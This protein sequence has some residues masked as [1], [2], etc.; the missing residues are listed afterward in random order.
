MSCCRAE[1]VRF[2]VEGRALESRFGRVRQDDSGPNVRRVIIELSSKLIR[3]LVE[4][5]LARLPPL[6]VLLAG[7]V[8][9]KVLTSIAAVSKKWQTG[10]QRDDGVQDARGKRPLHS[11]RLI[12]REIQGRS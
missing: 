12:K 8:I 6:L 1:L 4:E 5:L 11:L 7:V 9:L 10:L 3:P 2:V